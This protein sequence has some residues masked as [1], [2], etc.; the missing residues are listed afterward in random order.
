MFG[1]SRKLNTTKIFVAIIPIF[2]DGVVN[3]YHLQKLKNMH[4]ERAIGYM[5][6]NSRPV[7]L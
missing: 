3:C 1:F 7:L 6:E 4:V 2:S 5:I